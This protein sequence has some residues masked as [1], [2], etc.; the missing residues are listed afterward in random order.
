LVLFVRERTG[1]EGNVKGLLRNAREDA[2]GDVS[3]YCK[4]EADGS[5]I[6]D[7]SVCLTNIHADCDINTDLLM[8]STDITAFQYD[9][10]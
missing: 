9:M 5:D 6:E 10:I 8:L 2:C 3:K 7:L 4:R 1:L